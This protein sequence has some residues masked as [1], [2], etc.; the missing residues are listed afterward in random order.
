[1]DQNSGMSNEV[2]WLVK[3]ESNRDQ[4][5]VGTDWTDL[6]R[7]HMTT[8]RG[9]KL[10]SVTTAVINRKRRVGTATGGVELRTAGAGGGGLG[11]GSQGHMAHQAKGAS[12]VKA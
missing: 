4:K 6:L 12:K 7:N 8:I 9:R 2:Q 11:V 5:S 1:M 10:A 3:V